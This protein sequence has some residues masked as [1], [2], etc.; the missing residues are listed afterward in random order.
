M[1][2]GYPYRTT[3]KRVNA[4][5][6][7][8]FNYRKIN[9]K[10]DV[11]REITRFHFLQRFFSPCIWE[12]SDY[13]EMAQKRP[14]FAPIEWV[15]I[16]LVGQ[17]AKEFKVMWDSGDDSLLDDVAAC[18]LNGYKFSVSWDDRNN[19]WRCTVTTT[20]ADN[21][22]YGRGFS[23]FGGTP[24]QAMCVCAYKITTVTNNGL[25]EAAERPEFG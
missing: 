8:E 18:G 16:P 24:V 13:R 22:N 11:A 15:D 5:W 23:S 25:W 4:A 19:G 3:L 10:I 14:G 12:E 1:F 20:A 9:H 7:Q 17:H 2:Y 6:D 21:P